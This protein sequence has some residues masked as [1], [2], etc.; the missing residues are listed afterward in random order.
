MLLL[1]RLQLADEIVVVGVGDRGVVEL[2]VAPVVLG[3]LCSQCA[4]PLLDLQISHQR[5]VPRRSDRKSGR[6]G[7]GIR[8][9]TTRSV[10]RSAT[11]R[12]DIEPE[13]AGDETYDMLGPLDHVLVREAD[14][15]PAIEL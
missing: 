4:R 1:Q 7:D 11:E 8:A 2:V 14:D 12:G 15:T 6:S 3:D 9:A 13:H 5:I 10:T